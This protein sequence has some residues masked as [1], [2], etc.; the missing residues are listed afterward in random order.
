[1]R[2]RIYEIIEVAGE[3]DVLSRIYDVFMILVIMASLIPLAFK[4]ITPMFLWMD[5]VSTAIFILDYILRLVTADYKMGEKNAIAFFKYPFT[6]MALID[7]LSILPS[8][9]ILSNGFKI[10]KVIRLMRAFRVL[11]VLKVVRYSK[12]IL[13]L[14]KVF[15]KQKD[16][17]MVVFGLVVVYVL[18]SALVVFNVETDTFDS[19]FDAVYWATISLTTVGYGDIY[20]VSTAGQIITMI[21]SL[22]GVAVIALPAS[23]I[24]A[25]YLEEVNGEKD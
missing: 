9:S 23:I 16:A 11:R 19:F 13:L 10:T 5:R 20:P 7:L 25:G 6:P 2:K 18:I 3:D 17:L 22:I 1:M 21:S 15:K 14:L 8:L 12:N 24:T 4:H